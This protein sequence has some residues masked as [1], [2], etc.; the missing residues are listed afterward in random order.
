MLPSKSPA[1]I[2]LQLFGDVVLELT[3]GDVEGGEAVANYDNVATTEGGQRLWIDHLHYLDAEIA[4]YDKWW[5]HR[6]ARLIGFV[7]RWIDLP[8][9]EVLW[10]VRHGIRGVGQRGRQAVSSALQRTRSATIR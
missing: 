6:M 5:G 9:K 2:G 7:R 10:R 4:Y 3:G 1:T 8:L